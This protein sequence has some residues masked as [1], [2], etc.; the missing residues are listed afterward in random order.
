[1]Q[2]AKLDVKPRG[3]DYMI[4][5]SHPHQS[6]RHDDTYETDRHRQIPS[7]KT[8]TFFHSATPSWIGQPPQRLDRDPI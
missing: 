5:N 8:T 7:P 1:M 2:I 3:R 6:D 4:P